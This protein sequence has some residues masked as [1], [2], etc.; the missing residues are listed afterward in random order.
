[1]KR[2]A[3]FPLLMLLSACAVGPDYRRP[4]VALPDAYYRSVPGA[5]GRSIADAGW[6]QVFGDPQLTTLI[7]E[8]LHDNLDL[9][10]AASQIVQAEAQVAAARSPLFPRVLGQVQG[11]RSNQNVT[12]TTASSFLAALALS[13]EIDFWGR[14]LRATEAAR[15]SLLASEDARRSVIASLVSS[16]AQQYLQLQGLR[17]R[18]EI[19]QR[20]AIAQR[21]TLR[22]VTL[23]SQQGVQSAAEVR[24]AESQVLTTENQIPGIELQI[25]QAEDALALLLGKAPRS[26]DTSAGLTAAAVLPQVPAGVPSELLDRRPDIRQ[27]E[28]Q[29]V[30][31]NANIGVAK[32]QFFPS[33]SLTGS[34]GRA[35]DTL[36][37]VV[38]S[39]GQNVR[40]VAASV[41]QP[42]FEGGALVANYDIA[43]AQAEQAAVAYRRTIL[44]A[45][46]EV[47][48]ALVAFDRD[49]VAAEGNRN[50]VE[51][52]AEA[53]RLAQLRFRS[54]VISFL[55]VLD[56]QRQLLAAELDLNASELNQ[57][58]S[59]VQLYKALGGGWNPGK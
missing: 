42:L 35:S 59:A 53:L 45:L 25:A 40:S 18:L 33:I 44:I 13:W 34:L 48:D 2:C 32:A 41:N 1:M 8:A 10:I 24:Q 17:Q 14:Y 29:L 36:R 51:V 22:L 38:S 21:D 23:L 20:T 39:G 4:D 11:S 50:R 46:Q 55:E 54:G 16:V 30:A 27:A 26:F 43:R 57:R 12:F 9:A 6:W 31:A 37:G 15:A 49:R 28:Q 3:A 58:L 52:S 47:S 19:V 56:T 7:N 5:T